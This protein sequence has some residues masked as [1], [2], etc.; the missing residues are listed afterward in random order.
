MGFM[1]TRFWYLHNYRAL[2]MF[3]LPL[4]LFALDELLRGLG[5]LAKL[6]LRRPKAPIGLAS[7][8]QARVSS[9]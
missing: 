5:W 7:A 8:R 9:T 3:G 4:L 1:D 6:A 2:P